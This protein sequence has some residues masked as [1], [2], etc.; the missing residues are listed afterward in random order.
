MRRLALSVLA[1]L[2][3][4][5]AGCTTS[6]AAP[7]QDASRALD[8]PW[9]NPDCPSN[10]QDAFGDCIVFDVQDPGWAWLPN[11]RLPLPHAI[12]QDA[13]ELLADLPY[14]EKKPTEKRAGSRLIEVSRNDHNDIVVRFDGDSHRYVAVADDYNVNTP[15][16]RLRGM[17]YF[18]R[19]CPPWAK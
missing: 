4:L 14:T 19:P 12:G 6:V 1:G 13:C 8:P 9:V 17:P 3:V 10:Y 16:D 18:F 5:A 7:V 2:N 11:N 15:T